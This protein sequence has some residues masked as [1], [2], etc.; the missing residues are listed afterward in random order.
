MSIP[1]VLLLVMIV[2]L[3]LWALPTEGKVRVPPM[4]NSIG[5]KMFNWGLLV[6]LL[7]VTGTTVHAGR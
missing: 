5:E 7:V 2:G 4:V 6:T 3:V 1:V